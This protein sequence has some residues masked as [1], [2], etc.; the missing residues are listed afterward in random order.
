V[1]KIYLIHGTTASD[2][3][4]LGCD[5][6]G[7]HRCYQLELRCGTVDGDPDKLAAVLCWSVSQICT[8]VS[9]LPLIIAALPPYLGEM[10]L[11]GILARG[12]VLA[13]ALGVTV[14]AVVFLQC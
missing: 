3:Y 10:Q 1:R 7:T 9:G 14:A 2:D 13:I 11:S 5:R 4:L 6:S 8:G 12:A